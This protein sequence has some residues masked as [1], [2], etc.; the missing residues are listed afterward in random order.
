MNNYPLVIAAAGLGSRLFP[1]TWSVPKELFPLGN[2]PALHRVLEE[3][4]LAGINEL[5]CILSSRKN[6]ISDYLSYKHEKDSHICINEKEIARLDSL[7]ALNKHFSYQ[8]FYQNRALGVGHAL[9]Q[10]YKALSKDFFWVAHPDDIFLENDKS[11]CTMK[12]LHQETGASIILV[13]KIP[14]E[15]ITSYGVVKPRIDNDGNHIIM[16]QIV[17]KPSAENAPSEYAVIGRYLLNKRVMDIL[18]EQKNPC[19]ISALNQS[20][21]EGMPFIALPCQTKRYDIGT[22]SGWVNAITELHEKEYGI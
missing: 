13:E 10:S 18:N 3:A 11:M 7:D 1:A 19:F 22:V 21:K 8:F 20:M 12:K 2:T 16:E 4:Q 9:S 14:K 15:H 5:F 17:E 6:A